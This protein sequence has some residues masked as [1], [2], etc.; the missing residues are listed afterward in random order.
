MTEFWLVTIIM[1]NYLLILVPTKVEEKAR[2]SVS[3]LQVPS[4]LKKKLESRQTSVPSIT[5]ADCGFKLIRSSSEEDILLSEISSLYSEPCYDNQSKVTG[6]VTFR[7][8][9]RDDEQALYVKII[10]ATGLLNINKK[11]VNPY[12]KL[13]LLPGKSKHTKRKTTIQ[14]KTTSPEYNETAKVNRRMVL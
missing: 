14:Q 2:P 13:Y 7:I 6:N 3:S 5:D 8:W 4:H 11:D 12:I 9:Y 10:K 1:L